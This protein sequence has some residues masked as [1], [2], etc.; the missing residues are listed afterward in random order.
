MTAAQSGGSTTSP[1]AR[2]PRRPRFRLRYELLSCALHGHQLVGTDAAELRA[3]DQLIAREAG[4]GM[5]W[6]RC[7][8]CD[9]WLLLQ[10]PERAAVRHL[11]ERSEVTVPLR[12][13]PLR[14]RYVL[15]LIALDRWVHFIALA[16]I[17]VAIFVF[18]REKARLAG[19]FYNLLTGFQTAFGPELQSNS[20]IFADVERAFR[21]GSVT[22][23]VAG[24][25]VGAYALLEGV[26]GIGLWLGRRWAEYLTFIATAILLA[27]EIYELTDRISIAKVIAIVINLAIIAYLLIAKRLFGLRGGGR[28][29]AA[30]R[31]RDTGWSAVERALPAVTPPA[32]TSY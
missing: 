28:V 4:E 8:R 31:E 15:R 11:P 10:A 9:D 7:L 20:G 3:A 23:L 30:E 12:G 5:R 18:L 16:L 1:E 6:H 26:E 17:S 27:P 24:F 19:E 32:R 2:L 13:K 21:F 14:D 25:A 29:E 22:L